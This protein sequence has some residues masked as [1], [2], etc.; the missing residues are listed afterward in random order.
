MGP[1]LYTPTQIKTQISAKKKRVG[2]TP[3]IP[4]SDCKCTTT[5][6]GKNDGTRLGIPI[7]ILI[8]STTLITTTHQTHRDSHNTHPSALSPPASQSSLS[9]RVPRL[10]RPMQRRHLFPRVRDA[11]ENG[12]EF[13][14]PTGAFLSGVVVLNSISLGAVAGTIRST[15]TPGTWTC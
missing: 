8:I 14:V 1:Y 7:P 13:Y 11:M 12:D 15:Y 4:F 10:F 6:L 9:A 3:R 5:P 2:D